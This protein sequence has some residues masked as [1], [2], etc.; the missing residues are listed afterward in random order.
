MA[1][2]PTMLPTVPA[3]EMRPTVL[4]VF[5]RSRGHD[6]RDRA[7]DDG[8]DEEDRGDKPDDAEDHRPFVGNGGAERVDEEHADAGQ[9]G[10]QEEEAEQTGRGP[11]VGQ[12]AAEIVAQADAGQD[13][14]DDAGPGVERDTDVGRNHAAGDQFQDHD[15]GAGDEDDQGRRPQPGRSG[16]GKFGFHQSSMSSF[17]HFGQKW[18]LRWVTRMRSMGSPQRGQG[19]PT[20]PY[21]RRS[22]WK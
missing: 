4:P 22:F 7:E 18:V 13:D 21:T 9:A 3:A 12:L 14:A 11:A 8:G 15:A 10:E 2:V 1:K 16:L 20:L 5:A 19:M 17:W 6:G